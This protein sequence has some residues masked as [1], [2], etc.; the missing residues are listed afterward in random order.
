MSEPFVGQIIA[1][2][3]NFAPIGWAP[4]DGRTL[5]ISEYQVLYTLIGTTYGGNGTTTFNLPDLRG[6]AAINQGQGPALSSHVLG[7]ALG[8]ESVSLTTAQIGAHTHQ[9]MGAATATASTPAANTVLGTVTG[10]SIYLTS[11][12]TVPL[13]ASSIGMASGGALPH[14]NLQPYQTINYIIALNGIFPSQS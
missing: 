7:Q 8:V 9:L 4:C 13:A 11:G 6:R 3:F 14:D 2:G 1:V 5:A 10:E 12:S